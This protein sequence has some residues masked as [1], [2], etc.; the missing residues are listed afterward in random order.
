MTK[1]L[2]LFLFLIF[3]FP[4]GLSA[5]IPSP[6]SPKKNVHTSD[7]P[8]VIQPVH[9]DMGEVMEGKEARATLFLRNT[10]SLPVHVSKVES[11]CGCTT[12]SPGTRELSPGAFTPL[13]VRV[14]T[15]AK[16]GAVKKNITVFDNQGRKTQAWLTLIV[17]PN[18]HMG[19]M[20]GKGIFDGKCASCHAEPAR[21]KARGDAIY[22]AVCAMC[23]GGKAEG[24]YAPALR[25]RDAK[26]LSSVLSNGLGRRMPSFAKE[27]RGPLSRAQI[28]TVAKWL[29]K[30]DE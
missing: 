22:K 25:G 14:D 27:K 2:R 10:G 21:K 16:R 17:Q 7:A 20:R 24:A 15:T 19:A 12:V 9:M 26:F 23:H 30:L 29:S 4:I 8:L 1:K 5:C 6:P 13:H 28:A 3:T 11:S 18:P